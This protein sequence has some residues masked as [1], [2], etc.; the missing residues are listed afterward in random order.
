MKEY[1]E[2]WVSKSSCAF[3]RSYPVLRG[4][5]P[6]IFA[7]S[8]IVRVTERIDP[9]GLISLS[10]SQSVTQERAEPADHRGDR[11]SERDLLGHRLG[12]GESDQRRF[13]GGGRPGFPRRRGHQ[14]VVLDRHHP[15]E[16]PDRCLGQRRQL[17]QQSDDPS[18]TKE[19]LRGKFG[20]LRR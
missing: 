20:R 11:E 17:E 13:R 9:L 8:Q 19:Q 12:R 3:H 18:D 7:S 5:T 2:V 15:R 16:C 10:R 4:C 6:P 14:H 1:G